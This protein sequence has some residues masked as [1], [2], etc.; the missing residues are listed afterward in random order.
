VWGV[1]QAEHRKRAERAAKLEEQLIGSVW[2]AQTAMKLVLEPIF[3]TNF[4]RDSYGF[5]P[6]KSAQD[7]IS[8]IQ[9]S[10]T[11]QGYREVADIDLKSYF[12]T[13]DHSILLELVGR[14]VTDRPYAGCTPALA[15]MTPR[16]TTNIAGPTTR[17]KRLA[18]H[19]R[20]TAGCP[21]AQTPLFG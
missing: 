4:D 2:V 16:G 18:S 11:F 6:G 9:R 3:E 15:D 13:I 21:A 8:E 5:R 19:H 1:G 7:A 14:R 17:S 10:I 20:R 12:D